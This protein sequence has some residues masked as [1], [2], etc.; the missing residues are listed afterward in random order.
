MF[1]LYKTII[2]M[3]LQGSGKSEYCREAYAVLVAEFLDEKLDS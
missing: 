1:S 3:G 2:M